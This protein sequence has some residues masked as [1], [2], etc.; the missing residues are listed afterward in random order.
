[1]KTNQFPKHHLD[2]HFKEFIKGKWGPNAA[3]YIKIGY[4]EAA[5]FIFEQLNK[6][7]K[8]EKR[9]FHVGENVKLY[10]SFQQREYEGVVKYISH[11]YIWVDVKFDLYDQCLPFYKDETYQQHNPYLKIV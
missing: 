1:M 7:Q 8:A 11:K 6:P 3:I 4:E 9:K 5:R 2:R 10:H